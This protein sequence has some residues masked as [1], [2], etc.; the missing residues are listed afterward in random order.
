MAY[1]IED[2]QGGILAALRAYAGMP[3]EVRTIE[4]YHGEIPDIIDDVV[5]GDLDFDLNAVLVCYAGSKFTE[6]A[7]LSFTDEQLFAVTC[8]SENL[9]SREEVQTNMLAMLK[10]LKTCLIAEDLD[11]NIEPLKPVSIAL[12]HATKTVSIYSF[13]IETSFSMD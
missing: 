10:V 2:I 8:I 5:K 3:A 4:A 9:R 11:L 1:E 7:N 12:E 6:D 13:L